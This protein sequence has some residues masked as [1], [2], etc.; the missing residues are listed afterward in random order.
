MIIANL[1][2]NEI[3]YALSTPRIVGELYSCVY[4]PTALE[5]STSLNL[6]LKCT[7]TQFLTW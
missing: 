2:N 5:T 3:A 1:V 6:S 7:V 4:S